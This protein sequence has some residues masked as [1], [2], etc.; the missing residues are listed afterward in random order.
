MIEMEDHKRSIDSVINSFS[1]ASD[2]KEI[3]QCFIDVRDAVIKLGEVT[4]KMVKE[5]KLTP[6][7]TSSEVKDSK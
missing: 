6:P 2:M 3:T 5:L 4:E 7:N 1:K